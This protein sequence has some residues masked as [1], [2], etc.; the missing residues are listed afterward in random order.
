MKRLMNVFILCG[1]LV[2]GMVTN[3]CGYRLSGFTRQIPD[4]IKSVIIPNFENKTTRLQVEQYITF[5]VKEEFIKRSDLNL[6]DDESRADAI[7]EGT[8]SRFQVTPLSYSDDASANFYRVT[9]TVSVRFIDLKTNEV[10]FEG[11]DITYSDSYEFNVYGDD[12]TNINA[13]EDFFSQETE[14]I[15]KISEQFAASL[16]TTILE[17]F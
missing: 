8:I 4:Y 5:A 2:L 1:C 9:I 6:V 16:V 7:L 11:Q 14:T 12:V 3:N 13:E 10:I 17:N 15:I